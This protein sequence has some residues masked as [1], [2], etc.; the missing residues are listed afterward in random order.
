MSNDAGGVISQVVKNQSALPQ[1]DRNDPDYRRKVAEM[2][3]GILGGR[4]HAAAGTA[5]VAHDRADDF[6]PTLFAE[7][8]VDLPGAAADSDNTPVSTGGKRTLK[9][10]DD[11][12]DEV[13]MEIDL[14]DDKL[15]ELAK[16]A[17]RAENLEMEI[18]A[19]RDEVAGRSTALA[20]ER[21][22]VQKYLDM[23]KL[24]SREGIL[25]EMFKRDG[26]YEGLR[27]RIIEEYKGY[28]K[29]TTEERRDFDVKRMQAESARKMAELEKRLADRERTASARIVEADQ[30][31]KLA[32]L[33]TVRMKYAFENVDANPAVSSINEQIFNMARKAIQSLEG[34]GVTVTE[35]ILNREFRKAHQVFKGRVNTGAPAAVAN[36]N[37]VVLDQMDAA[38]A[39]AQSLP[40]NAGAGGPEGEPEI[41]RRWLG[42]IREGKLAAVNMEA[43]KSPKLNG[44]YAKLANMISRDRG[45]LSRK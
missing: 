1:L 39:A 43:T 7:P 22:K 3:E 6:R 33:N 41:I 30:A 8:D 23:E 17:R 15:T 35:N 18:N 44:L 11:I 25:D 37:K 38:A 27:N 45:L 42:M 26:G 2:A 16:R 29:M 12:D 24:G 13:E 20:S 14:S 31:Q 4:V 9:F 36:P 21:E 10:R 40:T 5:P 34:S 32:V 19:M 28:E